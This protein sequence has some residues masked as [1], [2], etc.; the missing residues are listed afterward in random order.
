MDQI[1][2]SNIAN[3]IADNDVNEQGIFDA[4]TNFIL[5]YFSNYGAE[6][7]E[8]PA[9]IK[10]FLR[11]D[12]TWCLK[13]NIISTTFH[14]EGIIYEIPTISQMIE[15]FDLSRLW[16]YYD[17]EKILFAIGFYYIEFLDKIIAEALNREKVD[18]SESYRELEK[19]SDID[20]Y[21]DNYWDYWDE[22]AWRDEIY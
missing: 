10:I 6:I 20:S 22:W 21:R 18:C 13:K 17:Q 16:T 19:L 8:E 4:L 12:G 11:V 9:T 14:Q 2:K 5:D 7:K 15:D 3:V 1:T